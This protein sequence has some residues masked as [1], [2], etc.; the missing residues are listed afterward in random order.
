MKYSQTGS[1]SVCGGKDG[2]HKEHCETQ[3]VLDNRGLEISTRETS[4]KQATEP[5]SDGPVIAPKEGS[6]FIK[7][8]DRILALQRER[9]DTQQ[10]MQDIEKAI[11]QMQPV[12]VQA[13]NKIIELEGVINRVNGNFIVRL[14][15][16]RSLVRIQEYLEEVR[17]FYKFT[18]G[19]IRDYQLK[20]DSLQETVDRI[21]QDLKN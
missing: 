10:E 3:K 5:S 8:T 14:F 7:R 2:I 15:K 13:Q 16:K 21:N 20:K 1:C 19:V 4:V 12:L 11:R 18:E 9:M 17:N 6:D